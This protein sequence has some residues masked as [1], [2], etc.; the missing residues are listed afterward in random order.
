MASKLS[1]LTEEQLADLVDRYCNGTEKV[2]DL[3][4]VFNINARPGDLA[5]LL[6]PTVHKDLWCEYCKSQNLIS[7]QES[8]SGSQWSRPA[9]ECPKC[10]H[11]KITNCRCEKC[12]QARYEKEAIIENAKVNLIKVTFDGYVNDLDDPEQLVLKDAIYMLSLI[13]HSL[14]D[15]LNYVSPYELKPQPL[16]PTFEFTNEI[17]KH[18]QSKGLIQISELSNVNAFEFDEEIT[19]IKGWYPDRVLWDFLPML[20]NSIQ[21]A[22]YIELLEELVL[23]EVEQK[24]WEKDI[25]DFWLEIAKYECFE[26]FE[27]LL[28]QRGFN[29]KSFGPKTHA[30]FE[31]LLKRYA[32]SQIFN[33]TWQTV[34]DIT[35]YSVKSN[36]PKY[37]AKNMFIGALQRKADKFQ[38]EGWEVKNSRRDFRCPQSFVS[39]TFFDTYIGFGKEAMDI[40]VP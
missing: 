10:G 2:V 5:R 15:D 13:R 26:Y 28:S 21:K 17:C 3:I 24:A 1:H 35:D 8:R 39:A 25:K 23:G 40:V 29:L 19:V 34:R 27:H 6:P 16:A 36:M 12:E 4:R 9:P 11:R 37:Q 14:S 20:T 7:R 30:V 22:R 18:L 32:V 38:A 31:N 33:L